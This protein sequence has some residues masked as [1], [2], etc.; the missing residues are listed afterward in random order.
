MKI[1]LLLIRNL[2]VIPE[3]SRF[4]YYYKEAIIFADSYL[5]HQQ[6]ILN[7]EFILLLQHSVSSK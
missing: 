7:C 5:N 1:L 2:G 6:Q 4:S 3:Q